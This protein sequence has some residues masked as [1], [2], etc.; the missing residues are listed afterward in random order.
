VTDPRFPPIEPFGSGVL[1]VGDGHLVHWECCGNPEGE[2][3]LLVHGGPGSGASSGQ[4]RLFD[5]RRYRAVIFDQ[6]GCGRSRPLASDAGADLR[7]NT[8]QHLVRDVEALRRLLRIERWSVILGLSW[9]TTLALAYAHAHPD[10]VAKL[11]LALVTTTSRREVEWITEGVGRI[12]PREW[13]RFASAVPERL[14]HLHLVDAYAEWLAHPDPAEHDAAAKEWCAWE[15]AHVSLTPGHRPSPL[16][17]DRTFRLGFARLVTHYWRHHA[18]LEE[19]QLVRDAAKL[20]GIPGT[21]IHGRFDVSSP[22][23]TPMRLA[24][25]W[26]GSVLHVLD[27]AGHGGAS[28]VPAIQRALER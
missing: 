28:V 10:R 14:R 3:A 9:G 25:R 21:L 12:F 26:R 1:D 2:P 16:F 13:A 6:R 17:V 7:A 27:D 8:T 5:P 19:D 23:E 24:E 22:L 20:D 4:R 18:F 11:V 15:D